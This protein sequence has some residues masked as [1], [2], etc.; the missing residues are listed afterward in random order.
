M[1]CEG[2]EKRALLRFDV[3]AIAAGAMIVGAR[4]HLTLVAE[5]GAPGS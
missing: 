3:A 1:S 4:L 2:T 5:I